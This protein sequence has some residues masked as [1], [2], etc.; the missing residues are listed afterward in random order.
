RK[1]PTSGV[2]HD[3]IFDGGIVERRLGDA[4]ADG[5][6]AERGIENQG[7]HDT[8]AHV[9]IRDELLLVAVANLGGVVAEVLADEVL[10]E[11]TTTDRRSRHHDCGRVGHPSSADG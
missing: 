6:T 2:A 8:T 3:A 4:D 1:F 7:E 11:R 10:V 9:M 5:G